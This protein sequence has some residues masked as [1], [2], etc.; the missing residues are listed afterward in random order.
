VNRVEVS[1]AEPG[2]SVSLAYGFDPGYEAVPGCEA[3]SLQIEGS[4]VVATAEADSLGSVLF[5]SP[6]PGRMAGRSVRLQAVARAECRVS[7]A[8]EHTFE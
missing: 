7:G 6:V 2:A 8:V 1:G 3:L 4:K 5:E